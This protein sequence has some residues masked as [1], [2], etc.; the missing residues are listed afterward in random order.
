[1][2]EMGGNISRQMETLRKKSKGSTRNQGQCNRNEEC[3]SW[4]HEKTEHG[5]EKNLCA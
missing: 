4:A 2:Q 5:Q 3:L 1:M